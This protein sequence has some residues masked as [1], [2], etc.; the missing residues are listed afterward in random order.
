MEAIFKVGLVSKLTSYFSLQYLM[1]FLPI[2]VVLYWL[3]P[4]KAR[5]WVLLIA[6]Y[7]F[8]WLISGKLTVFLLITTLSIY[9]FGLWLDKLNAKRKLAAKN[10]ADRAEKKAIKKA[11][12]TKQRWVVFFA[13]A[14]HIGTLLVLKYT[15][16]FLENVNAVIKACGSSFEIGIPKFLLPIGISFF[17]MQAMSYILDVYHGVIKADRNYLRISLYISFFPQIV[18]GPICKYADTAEQIY[19]VKQIS[20]TNLMLGLERIAYG[21][22][23]KIVVADRL[24]ILVET[25]Y[26][27][28]SKFGGATV[29]LGAVAYTIQLYMDFSGTMDAVCGT[30]QIFGIE[31]PENFKRPFFSKSISEFWKRWHITLGAWFRDYIFYPI[32]MSKPMKNL[33]TS[34]RKKVGNHFGPL[35]AGSI[36]LFAVW[37][38]NGLWHGAAWSYVFFGL[39]HF[40][41]ILS[42]NIITPFSKSLNEKLHIN[43][44]SFA[45][46]VMQMV[47]TTIFVIIGEMFF[48]ALTL[49]DGFAMFKKLVTEFSF[50]EWK[51]GYL[52]AFGVD[53]KDLVIVGVTLLII[54]VVSILNEKGINIRN[55]LLKKNILVRWLVFIALILF[56]L[57]FGAYGIGYE[58]VDP[59]YANF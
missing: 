10:A 1:L 31:M 35:I 9:L 39:Y 8:F 55:E 28:Y 18:E 45:Y 49:T 20:Y 26:N 11:Y 2:V 29:A 59:I 48:R 5:R 54:F 41:L 12:Q 56:I 52:K 51:A 6:S 58:P 40:A 19:E 16:F 24:N 13:T 47:R 57:I 7:A 36:A 14:V 23:K 50:A 42:G 38:S 44:E 22:M 43:E 25:I 33:T 21:L 3:M 53:V 34:A 4:R 30:A 15:P 46:K 37:F 17:S 32:S 27:D